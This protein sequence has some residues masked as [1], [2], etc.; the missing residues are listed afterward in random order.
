[1]GPVTH[2]MDGDLGRSTF[3]RH[4]VVKEVI[5]TRMV[6]IPDKRKKW[7]RKAWLL[8]VVE[9]V[10]C[11]YEGGHKD[12]DIQESPEWA[13]PELGHGRREVGGEEREGERREPGNLEAIKMTGVAV[14]LYYTGKGS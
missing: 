11:R 10:S 8:P 3:H 14:W 12:R 5:T 13:R 4:T 9:K 2:R 7:E 6:T 1:M